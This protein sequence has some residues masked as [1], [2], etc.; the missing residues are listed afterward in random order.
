MAPY[1]LYA[2]DDADDKLWVCEAG[3]ALNSPLQFTFVANGKAA[4]R[5]L[6]TQVPDTLPSLIVLDL[7]MPE[8]DGRQTLK[9]LKSD[10]LYAQVPVVV[11][12]TSSSKLDIEVCR[13]L[14]ASAF[15]TK[16]LRHRQWQDIIKQLE[17]IAMA[18]RA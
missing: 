4:L 8:L 6:Q 10:P 7:N 5:Y 13:H 1:V 12:S 15:L 14:G 3:K 17:P 9:Q 16:P 11:V 18:H 2:D